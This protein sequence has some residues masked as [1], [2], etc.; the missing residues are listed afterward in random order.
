MEDD[1]DLKWLKVEKGQLTFDVEGN[2]LEDPANPLHQYFSRKVHWPGGASGITIGR[3]YDLGQRPNP[4][5]D[6]SAVGIREPL[7]SWL[8]GAKGLSGTAARNYLN[9]ASQEI[10]STFITRKQQYKLFESVYEAKKNEVITISGGVYNVGTYGALNWGVINPKIQDM[11]V[12]LI[13]R[14]DYIPSTREKVQ[15]PFVENN[16]A[17]LKSVMSDQSNWSSVPQDRF[18]KRKNY[19]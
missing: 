9:S 10:K 16:L 6:L 7:L 11:I 1:N 14:G 13:Y 15:R 2:D 12:D 5:S 18:V 17:E 4:Q 3:G 8:I 19:L